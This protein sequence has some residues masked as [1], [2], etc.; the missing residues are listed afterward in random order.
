MRGS[1]AGGPE[2]TRTHGG[3]L[4]TPAPPALTGHRLGAPDA[5]GAHA[6]LYVMAMRLIQLGQQLFH[7]TPVHHSDQTT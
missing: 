4:A 6:R 2:A 7:F 3:R 5:E 1:W